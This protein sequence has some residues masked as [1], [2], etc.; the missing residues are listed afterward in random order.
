MDAASNAGREDARA[1]VSGRFGLK[2]HREEKELAGMA[3]VAESTFDPAPNKKT[4]LNERIR[5]MP[6]CLSFE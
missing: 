4:T 5:W 3:L 6:L 2:V 1:P